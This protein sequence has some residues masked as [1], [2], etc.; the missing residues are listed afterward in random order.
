MF[1]KMTALLKEIEEV[2]KKH[3]ATKGWQAQINLEGDLIIVKL[4]FELEVKG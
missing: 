2:A 3:D 1:E 4:K